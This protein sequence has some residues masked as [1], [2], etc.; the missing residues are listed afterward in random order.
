MT[1]DEKTE[2][3][4]YSEDIGLPYEFI[5]F[6]KAIINEKKKYAVLQQQKLIPVSSQKQGFFIAS[7]HY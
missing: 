6:S 5:E 3:R 4:K 1:D 2:S 7:P